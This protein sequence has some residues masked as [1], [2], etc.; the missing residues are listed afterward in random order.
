MT[1]LSDL[2]HELL[3]LVVQRVP[4]I[5]RMRLR[6]VNS[7]LQKA[8]ATATTSLEISSKR[9]PMFRESF[10]LWLKHH[11]QNVLQFKGVDIVPLSDLPSTNLQH[12]H[13]ESCIMQP[14]SLQAALKAAT[15]LTYLHMSNFVLKNDAEQLY[16]RYAVPLSG[17]TFDWADHLS[18]LTRLQH[19]SLT[20][21]QHKHGKVRLS[22]NRLLVKLPELTHLNLDYTSRLQDPDL[23]DIS[24]LIF[25]QELKVGRQ[26]N[27]LVATGQHSCWGWS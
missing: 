17:T 18:G 27:T 4:V 23:Q 5:D 20:T 2:S 7:R 25:L 14:S 22:G 21:I 15:A 19:L 11:Q 3:L 24:S 6:L 16:G 26:C 1:S 13:L 12:L 8:A 9:R 10:R